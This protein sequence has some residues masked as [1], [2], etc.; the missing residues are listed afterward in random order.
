VYALDG[1]GR[2]RAQFRDAEVDS[3]IAVLSALR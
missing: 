3:M 2:V 1:Q